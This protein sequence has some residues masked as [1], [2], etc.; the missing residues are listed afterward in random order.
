[1]A[2]VRAE[3]GREGEEIGASCYGEAMKYRVAL[4][5]TEEGYSVSCPGL[6][7]CWSQGTTE[8]EALANIRSAIEEYL[9]SRM[10]LRLRQIL[11]KSSPTARGIKMSEAN[12]DYDKDGLALL[13]EFSDAI[14]ICVKDAQYGNLRVMSVI[15]DDAI[16]GTHI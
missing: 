4:R 16:P 12:N 6:P 14:A 7:G 2:V 5:K 9:A 15:E 13:D 10:G 11:P 3:P 1:M 8:E